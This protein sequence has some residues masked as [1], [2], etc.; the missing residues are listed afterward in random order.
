MLRRLFIHILI[1]QQEENKQM[2]Q[3]QQ[4]VNN[5]NLDPGERGEWLPPSHHDVALSLHR[6]QSL[7]RLLQKDFVVTSNALESMCVLNFKSPA[8]KRKK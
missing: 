8:A 4:N 5:L 7:T 2:K 6:S 3:M 1:L